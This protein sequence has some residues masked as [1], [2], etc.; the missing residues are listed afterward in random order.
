MEIVTAK[1]QLS[2]QR[3]ATFIKQEKEKRDKQFWTKFT[4]SLYLPAKKL[5]AKIA[6]RTA[7]F[8]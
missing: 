7:D 8:A 5:P 3:T 2:R 1:A 4:S 6:A